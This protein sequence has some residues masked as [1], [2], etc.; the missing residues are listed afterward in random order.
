MHYMRY[1]RSGHDGITYD[2]CMEYKQCIYTSVVYNRVT[3]FVYFG[4]FMDDGRI[5]IDW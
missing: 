3:L 5:Y 1:L 4:M 2:I